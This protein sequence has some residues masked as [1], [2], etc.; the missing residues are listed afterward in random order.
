[1][2]KKNLQKQTDFLRI[3]LDNSKHDLSAIIFFASKVWQISP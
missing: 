1:M 3:S 2:V